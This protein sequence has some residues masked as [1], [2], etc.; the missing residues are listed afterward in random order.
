MAASRTTLAWAAA[1]SLLVAFAVFAPG[2]AALAQVPGFAGITQPAPGDVVSGVVTIYGT[3]DHPAFTA[4]DLAFAYADN[5]T[6]TW[7]PLGEPVQ[8][9]VV[10]GRLGLW[11]T[12][13]I[14]DGEYRLRL[15]VWLQD[16]TALEDV[17]TG[18]RVRNLSPAETPTPIPAVTLA[19]APT[20]TP[21][22]PLPAAAS[23]SAPSPPRSR[24]VGALATG[25]LAALIAL[26]L[27]ALYSLTRSALRPRW[28]DLRT[29]YF[30]W[31]DR[32]RRR[33][34]RGRRR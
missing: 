26:G 27:L 20:R 22:A 4:Y 3:A 29:R 13:E 24:A 21:T 5:P 33:R 15:R 19:P 7:F 25:V 1:S 2:S 31:Q 6:N 11:D 30:H 23:A 28:A 34:G 17:V 18:V 14:A 16:G 10:D 12:N 9:P 32:R 8:V